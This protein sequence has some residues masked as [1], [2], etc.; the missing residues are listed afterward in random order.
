MKILAIRG[1]NLASL[2][3]E[4]EIDLAR[5]PIGGVGVFAIVGPTGAGKSTL[6][7]AMC[8]ALFDRTPRLTNRSTVVVGRDPDDPSAL[9]AQDVRTILRR[10]ASA[11]WA[12]VDF[13]SGDAR[14]YRARWSVRR[15][16]NASDGTLQDQQVTLTAIADGERLGGTKT[17]T[18]KA[19][20]ERLGLSFDQFRRSA[21]LAQGEFAAFLRADGKDRSELLERMTGTEIYSRLSVAAHERATVAEQLVRDA[22]ARALA[23]AVLDEPNRAAMQLALGDAQV[24]R[25]AAR[26]AHA[27]A[28]AAV[29]WLAEAGARAQLI[30]RAQA[31]ADAADAAVLA[32][33]G[34]RSELAV[35]RRAETLRAMW[36][37]VARAD[38]QLAAARSELAAATDAATTAAARAREIAATRARLVGLREPITA[39]RIAAGVAEGRAQPLADGEARAVRAA[40]DAEWI[41]ARSAIA[42]QVS[43]WRDGEAKV[44]AASALEAE[45]AAADRALGDLEAKRVALGERRKERVTAQQ[46]ATA[47]LESARA[48]AARFADR[49]GLPFETARRQEDEARA[50]CVEVDKLVAIAA[51]AYDAAVARGEL[52]RQLGELAAAQAADSEQRGVAEAAKATA[53]VIR[54]ERE[55]IVA[56]LRRAAGYEHARTE[57]VDGDPCPLCGALE[58]P[59]HGRG[60]FDTLIADAEAQLAAAGHTFDS[61]IGELAQLAARGGQRAAEKTRLDACLATVAAT[62]TAATSAWRGQLGAL[63]ELLLVGEPA[64][65]DARELA[66]ERAAAAKATL[67]A[68]RAARSHAEAAVKAAG[69]AVARVQTCQADVELHA[70]AVRDVDNEIA[71]NAAAVER[72]HGERAGKLERQRELHADVA[73]VFTRW[74]GAAANDDRSALFRS[75]AKALSSTSHDGLALALDRARRAAGELAAEWTK[76]IGLIVSLDAALAGGVGD[77][78]RLAREGERSDAELAARRGEAE[79]RTT[80][81]A[82]QRATVAAALDA[83]RTAAGF[84][85]DELHDAL[86]GSPARVDGRGSPPAGSAAE[87]RRGS[88][89][90]L[91]ERLAALDRAADHASAI[92]G[93]RRAHAAD[94]EAS[95]P[96]AIDSAGQ[97][98]ALA[99]QLDTLERQAAELAATL[100]ADAGARERRA[101]ALAAVDAAE[102]AAEIDRS[103]GQVIGSHDGKLFRSFAQS[104]TLDGLLAVANAHLEELAPRY[105]LERVPR[106]DLELQIIDRDLGGEIRSVQSLS[107]GESFLV[108]LALAL[109]LSS[110]SAQDVRVR[111]LLIDE[112]FGTLDPATLDAALSVLDALQATGRQVGVISHVPALIE[113][114]GAHISGVSRARRPQR[115]DRRRELERRER[116]GVRRAE[117]RD[118]HH[119]QRGATTAR[120]A[121][122]FDAH[123]RRYLAGDQHHAVARQR[124]PL[125]AYDERLAD[126]PK[127]GDR[128]VI[129]LE[130]AVRCEL[131][132]RA[133]RCRRQERIGGQ[134]SLRRPRVGHDALIAAPTPRRQRPIAGEVDHDV[135]AEKELQLGDAQHRCRTRRQRLRPRATGTCREPGDDHQCHDLRHGSVV[136]RAIAVGEIRGPTHL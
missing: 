6:L 125:A 82:D 51:Q 43:G 85:S 27:A 54:S 95:R 91:A 83:A 78:D 75:A 99:D 81:L 104:L 128:A 55:R 132:G 62:A 24:A 70:T 111:T 127:V 22:R 136:T 4:F 65:L 58:H 68:A 84:S 26:D 35:R 46:A 77:A 107:G 92:V 15:A 8:V 18:L 36:D 41:V 47:R 93:E 122:A 9:G 57:L 25:A 21:L 97:V 23:I 94:H 69:E 53:G 31:A 30:E 40:A 90:E 12:E 116:D 130:R 119:E 5:A 106:H 131:T 88:I 100:A 32:A 114:V 134:R 103:L 110:M 129:R 17:E 49:R 59:W 102:H 45:L 44:A 101:A 52:D 42:A 11:G 120:V 96:A 71:A 80:E 126:E 19:I 34:E 50:C 89:E 124:D 112:G 74:A 87:C 98:A 60:A 61:A 109:G 105:Q 118:R 1:C 108:S 121:R 115:R 37:D 133:T 14:R 135:V 72:V 79:R 10:G 3:G 38:R 2:A 39:A 67:D 56:E 29:R 73:A 76:R 86:A 113:R 16:R 28:E 123:P 20:H 63:G 48:E 33:D 117:Q 66:I 64:G 7:D 13:E